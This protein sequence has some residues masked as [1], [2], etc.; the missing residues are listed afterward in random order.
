MLSPRG[1]PVI[2]RAT[3]FSTLRREIGPLNEV[4]VQGAEALLAAIEADPHRLPDIRYSA[5]MLGTA[6]HETAHTLAPIAERGD[7]RYFDALYD[8]IGGST[9]ARRQRARQMGNTEP[10]DGYRYRGRGYVQL[11]WQRNYRRAGEALGIDLVADPDRALEPAI[12]YQIMSRGM[13][14]GWFSGRALDAYLTHQSTDYAGARAVVNGSDRA[15]L[16]AQYAGIFERALGAAL[17]AYTW[18]AANPSPPGLP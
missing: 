11:T 16:V 6:W 17:W 7:R 5:Y 8:P 15:L 10:G 9:A 4:Q 1:V 3:F 13:V 18:L 14:E 12:A 2:H